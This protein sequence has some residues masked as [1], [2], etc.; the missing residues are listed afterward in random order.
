MLTVQEVAEFLKVDVRTVRSWIKQDN[1]PAFRLGRG[2]RIP[3][4]S[5]KNGSPKKVFRSYK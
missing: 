2:Y 4:E 3:A 5:W 1:L